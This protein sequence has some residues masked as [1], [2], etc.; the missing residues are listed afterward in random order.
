MDDND[1]VLEYLRKAG[2][3]QAPGTPIPNRP[4][5]YY[6]DVQDW[7]AQPS[8]DDQVKALFD[9]LSKEQN[10]DQPQSK[11]VPAQPVQQTQPAA[12]PSAPA[13]QDPYEAWAQKEQA[14]RQQS[15]MDPLMGILGSI[16]KS[17]TPGQP[18]PGTPPADP[19][20]A[21]GALGRGTGLMAPSK[22]E[23]QKYQ[24]ENYQGPPIEGRGAAPKAAP[25]QQLPNQ[26]DM[27]PK[28]EPSTDG[29]EPP[30]RAAKSNEDQV[31]EYVRKSAPGQDD[32]HQQLAAIIRQ[33]A[34][35]RAM[36]AGGPAFRN[37]Q[38]LALTTG[39]AIRTG[40]PPVP[41]LEGDNVGQGVAA[42]ADMRLKALESEEDRKVKEAQMA[43]AQAN[44]DR[45]YGNLSPKVNEEMTN[46]RQVLVELGTI[47]KDIPNADVGPISGQYQKLATKWGFGTAPNVQLRQDFFLHMIR[48]LKNFAGVRGAAS[49]E[50]QKTIEAIG[51]GQIQNLPA[52]KQAL[53]GIVSAMRKDYNLQWEMQAN[54]GKNV[55]NLRLEG[56][57]PTRDSLDQIKLKDNYDE[58][59]GDR[60]PV[61]APDGTRGTINAKDWPEAQKKGYKRQ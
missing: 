15:W 29:K 16:G 22:E 51:L 19:I 37:M 4:A 21:I 40:A 43:E 27:A 54:Q 49:P 31:G 6:R 10:W 13:Q 59:Q 5:S 53:H 1:L 32:Y 35:G 48:L 14:K 58:E 42:N 8:Q 45:M 56:T 60:I 57:V 55:Q 33:D 23:F 39:S 7:S 3:P 24:E 36:A 30:P 26:Q 41:Q 20:G 2:L 11:A 18:P 50:L 9:Q 25:A 47:E 38:R 12:P 61:I 34:L 52:L 44:K 17:G 46:T 28:F